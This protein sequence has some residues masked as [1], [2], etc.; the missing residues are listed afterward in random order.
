MMSALEGG[1]G[2]GEAHRVGKV[3]LFFSKNQIQMRTRGE[4]VKK[5]EIFLA[6]ISG[7]S[8]GVWSSHQSS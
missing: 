3:V 7:R 6:I 1:G 2:H 8:L 4:G 5:S